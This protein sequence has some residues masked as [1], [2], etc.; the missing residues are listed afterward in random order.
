LISRFICP[1]AVCPHSVTV[2]TSVN[3]W[4]F[5]SLAIDAVTYDVRVPLGRSQTTPDVS[6]DPIPDPLLLTPAEV[7]VLKDQP[8]TVV[9]LKA[10]VTQLQNFS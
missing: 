1:T 5:E 7:S 10:R 2:L 3:F 8:C 4:R 9:E 6:A